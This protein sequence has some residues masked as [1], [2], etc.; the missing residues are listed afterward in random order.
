LHSINSI[1]PELLNLRRGV[2]QKNLSLEKIKN[3]P[4]SLPSLKEQKNIVKALDALSTE[5]KRLELIYRQKL[6]DFDELKKSI[7]QKAF[8]GE[9]NID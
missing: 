1:K 8:N 9:L 2:R 3:I 7:L 4:I 5:T 6:A